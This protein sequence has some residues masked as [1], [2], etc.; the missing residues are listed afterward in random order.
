MGGNAFRGANQVGG[1]PA[2]P[3]NVRLLS[4]ANDPLKTIFGTKT[5][6]YAK[7]PEWTYEKLLKLFFLILRYR[8]SQIL[9]AFIL[10]NKV[11]FISV[12][13]LRELAKRPEV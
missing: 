12:D 13:D 2:Q 10:F 9:Y 11:I 5:N 8:K 6:L 4:V 3:E 7:Q 1:P